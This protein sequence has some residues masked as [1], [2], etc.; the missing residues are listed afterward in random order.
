VRRIGTAFHIKAPLRDK[1]HH[2]VELRAESGEIRRFMVHRLVL[3]LFVGPCPEGMEGCHND[4]NH[5]NNSVDNLRW[6]TPQ[7]NWADRKRHGRGVEGEKNSCAK[8]NVAAV[9]EIRAA[10][11][12]GVSLK[13]LSEQFGVS[14]TKISHVASG[15]SWKHVREFP[16]Y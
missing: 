9:I 1:G 12:Q 15:K 7:A 4:G 16:I 5:A 13:A 11:L 10:R 14:M 3:T 8:L 2:R 6:D